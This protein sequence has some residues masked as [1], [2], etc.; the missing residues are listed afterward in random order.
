MINN[1]LVEKTV[2]NI[3]KY[4]EKYKNILPLI[5]IL[6]TLVGGLWQ[7]LEL[8]FIDPSLIRFFSIS[9]LISDGI[10]I[11]SIFVIFAFYLYFLN[12]HFDFKDLMKFDISKRKFNFLQF[13]AA[14]FILLFTSL[15]YYFGF[16]DFGSDYYEHSRLGELLIQFLFAGIFLPLMI[17]GILIISQ[18]IFILLFFNNRVLKVKYVRQFRNEEGILYYAVYF[19]S[20]LLMVLYIIF[21]IALI[22][23]LIEFRNKI[24]YPQNLENIKN[25]FEQ[26]HNEFGKN[27]KSSILYFNDTYIF[28]ELMNEKANNENPARIKIYK[29]DDVLFK[30]TD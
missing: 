13:L 6:P 26:V 30:H 14:L 17:K 27:Q 3:N 15:F 1:S 11:L 16:K 7:I 28:V 8:T 12:N 4:T 5:L 10:L 25:I 23:I 20:K 21:F 29:T 2:E 9:Q 24:L 22:T 19:L 18:E